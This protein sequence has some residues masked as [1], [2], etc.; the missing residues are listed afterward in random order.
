MQPSLPGNT[1]ELHVVPG[2]ASGREGGGGEG[3]C[4]CMVQA[5]STFALIYCGAS[6][7]V[8]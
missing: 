8:I 7:V 6:I 2:T 5:Y 1:I 3:V 4:K